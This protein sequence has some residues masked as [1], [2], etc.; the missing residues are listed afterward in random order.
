MIGIRTDCGSWYFLQ[1]LATFAFIDVSWLF[2]RANGFKTAIK[3]LKQVL[4][5]PLPALSQLDGEMFLDLIT[6]GYGR[7]DFMV[8]LIFLTVLLFVDYFRIRV[9]LKAV[10]A[11]QNLWFRWLVYYAL[12][13]SVLIFGVYGPEYTASQFIY[14]Q[15]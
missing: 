1:G 9:D 6:L 5:N 4:V 11:R 15:F 3:M 10:L 13:F 8:L 2:F 12:I 7:A 14:F